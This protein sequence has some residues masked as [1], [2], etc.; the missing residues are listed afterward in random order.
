MNSAAILAKENIELRAANA[1]KSRKNQQSNHYI[2][3]GLILM[4]PCLQS[5]SDAP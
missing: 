3:H 4:S 5:D 2:A 1:H